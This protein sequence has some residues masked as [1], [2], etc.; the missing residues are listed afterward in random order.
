MWMLPQVLPMPVLRNIMMAVRTILI[1]GYHIHHQV[2]YMRLPVIVSL[3]EEESYV[4]Q[5]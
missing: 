3:S 5:H 4:R 1:T 2:L